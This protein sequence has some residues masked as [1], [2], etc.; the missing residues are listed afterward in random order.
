MPWEPC[1]QRLRKARTAPALRRSRAVLPVQRH[2]GV[3]LGT[4]LR[5]CRAV[6]RGCVLGGVSGRRSSRHRKVQAILSCYVPMC[7]MACARG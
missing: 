1:V 3:L 4:G 2:T 7:S 5:E 6:E